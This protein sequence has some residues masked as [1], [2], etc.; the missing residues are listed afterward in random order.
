MGGQDDGLLSAFHDS[1]SIFPALKVGAFT[2]S[3]GLVYGA[4]SGVFRAR[5]PVIRSISVGVHWLAFGTS[6]WWLRSNILRLQY[7]KNATLK[8][9][10]YASTIS[11][12]LAGGAVGWAVNRRFVPGLI[13]CSILGYVGQWSYD[14]F[15]DRQSRPK[16]EE[17]VPK[18]S[19]AQR[20]AASKW[21]PIR[22]LSDEQYKEMLN[23]KLLQVDVEI[24]LIDDRIATL[25]E[26]SNPVITDEDNIV[27]K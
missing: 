8:E 26:A 21:M 2:G 27:K 3:C 10:A 4:I 25:K 1:G 14:K 5:H 20:A 12:G 9:R 13:A 22:N 11:G 23:E 15:E 6:F 16:D 18:G 17:M 7:K 19:W 24:A